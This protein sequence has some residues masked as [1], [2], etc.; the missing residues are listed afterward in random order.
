M[1]T[2]SSDFN[3]EENKIVKVFKFNLSEDEL[4]RIMSA[5]VNKNKDDN[6]TVNLARLGY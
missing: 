2:I 3:V 1:S 5:M 6:A 4:K